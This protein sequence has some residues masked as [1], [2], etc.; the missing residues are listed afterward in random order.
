MAFLTKGF[1]IAESFLEDVGGEGKAAARASPPEGAG[2]DGGAPT[3]LELQI[4]DLHAQLAEQRS[5]IASLRTQLAECDVT[6]L[7]AARSALEDA[8]AAAGAAADGAAAARA[9][10]AANVARAAEE[11]ASSEATLATARADLGI[12]QAAARRR[13]AQLAGEVE[14]LTRQ[15]TAATR[16]AD[17]A[18]AGPPPATDSAAS[19]PKPSSVIRALEQTLYDERRRHQDVAAELATI[20]AASAAAERERAPLLAENTALKVDLSRLKKDLLVYQGTCSPEAMRANE[21]RIVGLIAALAEA[22]TARERAIAE[23]KGARVMVGEFRTQLGEARRRCEDLESK[24]SSH[25]SV[26][27]TATHLKD[28]RGDRAASGSLLQFVDSSFVLLARLFAKSNVARSVVVCYLATLH[29]FS[30]WILAFNSHSVTH[31]PHNAPK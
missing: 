19:G 3:A 12:V 24:A 2:H 17:I 6:A 13:E 30:F 31:T 18:L 14:A 25:E 1:R 11:V 5:A 28:V 7:D 27:A 21:G 29:V 15:L 8:R 16:E 23:A 22:E 9:S 10:A 4:A 20:R 26:G